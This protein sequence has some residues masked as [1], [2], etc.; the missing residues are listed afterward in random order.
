VEQVRKMMG[1]HDLGYPFVIK[2][3]TA[4]RNKYAHS[5]YVVRSESGLRVALKFQGFQNTHLIF[6]E[7]IQHHE[8]LYKQYCIGPK[9]HDYIIMTSVPQQLI[10]KTDAFFFETKMKFQAADFT[11]FDPN[12][13]RMTQE[14]R[15]VIAEQICVGYFGLNL[16]GVDMLFEENTG[17]IY[18]I[19]VNYFSSY[20]GLAHL[21]VE[22]AFKELIAE[23]CANHKL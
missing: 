5:F 2:V 18:L 6:Q 10:D 23:K 16:V 12:E 15:Q 13:D 8:Q 3:L 14:V 19:D 7:W 22:A 17:N 9:H 21:D 11:K 1:E 4:S 20:K